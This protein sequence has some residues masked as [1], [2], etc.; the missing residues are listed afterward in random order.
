VQEPQHDAPLLLGV[1]LLDRA[2]QGHVRDVVDD[3]RLRA[4]LGPTVLAFGFEDVAGGDLEAVPAGLEMV[5][6][7][8]AGDRDQPGAQ[9]AALPREAA[10]ALERA[11]ERVRREVLGE[12]A[13][14][15]PEVH[16][17]E[18]G[19]EV[20]VVDQ[21]ERLGLA[22]LC[23]F[24]QRPHRGGRVAGSRPARL[25]PGSA[26]STAGRRRLRRL[27]RVQHPE[28]DRFAAVA[29][30]GG[31]PGGVRTVIRRAARGPAR[32]WAH[33]PRVAARQVAGRRLVGVRPLPGAGQATLA[34]Q[35][36]G[37]DLAQRGE[38]LGEPQPVLS[39]VRRCTHTQCGHSTSLAAAPNWCR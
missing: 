16:E 13:V 19:V 23:P 32:R 7:Q 25:L 31:V 34:A 30:H 15:D 6:H 29:G 33:R 11:Q 20:P 37:H 1:E 38:A 12:L 17:P 14:A 10:D 4:A 35:R 5:G 21:P 39:R 9:V 26:R 3:G 22:R 36:R 2:Q 28:R 27:R 24:D 18:H 8:V